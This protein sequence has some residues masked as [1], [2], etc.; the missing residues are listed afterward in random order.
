LRA[1]TTDVVWAWCVCGRRGGRVRAMRGKWGEGGWGSRPSSPPLDL[2][3][4]GTGCRQGSGGCGPPSSGPHLASFSLPSQLHVEAAVCVCA[5]GGR[6]SCRHLPGE[7]LPPSLSGRDAGRVP[8][9]AALPPPAPTSPAS[10]CHPSSMWKPPCVCVHRA[11]GSP[12]SSPS[13]PS[14]SPG[15]DRTARAQLHVVFP[16][17]HALWRLSSVVERG[18][19]VFNG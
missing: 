8:A 3:P 13:P 5:L 11:G 7:P 6:L 17:E 2:L 16:Y 18:T 10:L 4:L 1:C 12:G 9:A 14:P 19:A 15:W